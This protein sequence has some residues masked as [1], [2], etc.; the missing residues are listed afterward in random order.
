MSALGH[1]RTLPNVC[2]MSALPLIAD[3]CDAK[4]NVCFGPTADIDLSLTNR[5]DGSQLLLHSTPSPPRGRQA[6]AAGHF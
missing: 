6:H 1:K 4:T 2:A 3:M 5:G